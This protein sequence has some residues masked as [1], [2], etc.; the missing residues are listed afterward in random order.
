M[1]QNTSSLLMMIL[2]RGQQTSAHHRTHTGLKSSVLSLSEIYDDFSAGNMDI[3]AI[4]NAIRYAYLNNSDEI[5]PSMFV[6]L[7]IQV[8]TTKIACQT[9]I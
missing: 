7:E 8:M 6:C 2:L 5:N 4:R 3:V 9:I 1:K